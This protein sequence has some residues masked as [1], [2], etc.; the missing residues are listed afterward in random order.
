MKSNFEVVVIG[1][2]S[3]G[4]TAALYLKRANVDVSIIENYAPG[5]QLNR[6]ARID[7]YPGFYSIEG[8]SLALNMF[9]QIQELK[10]PYKQA[11]VKKIEE[12]DGKKIIK[13]DKEDIICDAVI[14]AT[15][16]RARELGLEKEKKLAGRGISWCAV[17][18]GPLYKGKDVIVIG[19]GNSAMD[20]SNYLSPLVNKLTIIHRKDE[21]RGD[22]VLQSRIINDKKI[23]I[24]YNSVVTKI[25]EKNNYFSGVEIENI[26]TKEKKT[27]Q[28][29]GLFIYIGFDPVSD[30]V[31]E[32]GVNIDNGYILVDA[33]MRTNIKGIYACGDIIKKELYQIA[34]A[35]GEGAKAA[36][37]A[38]QDLN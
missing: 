2:G 7:N 14:I 9:T 32:I 30:M 25:N 8:P 20:E 13:T 29:E 22:R 37:S 5:G 24:I 21:F 11:T 38:I 27:I 31:T 18:D 26:T 36:Y 12:K 10:I 23:E 15:G 3:A 6:T 19:G 33:N 4:M 17:C 1:S 28:A 35:V 34:T 16:R